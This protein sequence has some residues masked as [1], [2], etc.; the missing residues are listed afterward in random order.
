MISGLT[1]DCVEARDPGQRNP[2]LPP[3]AAV[4]P[5]Q[6]WDQRLLAAHLLWHVL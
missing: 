1:V 3:A 4:A 5:R 2:T 6:Q